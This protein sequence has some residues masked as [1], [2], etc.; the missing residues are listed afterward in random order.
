MK[1]VL[2]GL[3]GLIVVAVAALFI[4]PPLL[5]WDFVKERAAVAVKEATGRDL[6][7]ETLSLSLLPSVSAELKG[8]TL[9]NGP[10]MTSAQMLSMDSLQ[11]EMGLFPLIG[12]SI[13]VQLL[14]LSGLKVS[15][16]K[17]A[18]GQA[19]WEFPAQPKSRESTGKPG[20]AAGGFD[21][22]VA[23]GDV[24][25]ENSSITYIDQIS[26]QQIEI[27]DLGV[28]ATLP[29]FASPLDVIGSFEL[30][31]ERVDLN[32]G[33]ETPKTLAEGAP[34]KI[35]ASIASNHLNLASALTLSQQPQAGLDGG[36]EL[37]IASV[38]ALLSWLDQPLPE[39]QPDPGPVKIAASFNT[40]GN[41][42]V[43]E[44]AIVSGDALDARAKGRFETGG[45][46][47]KI[48]LQLES[49]V[50][51]IDRY[52]PP[53]SDTGAAKRHA[54]HSGAHRHEGGLAGLSGEPI[55]LSGLKGT[56]ADISI[57]MNGIRAGGYEVGGIDFQTTLKEG[58]L[59]AELS[60][61]ELYGGRV[62]GKVSLDGSGDLLDFTSD[63]KIDNVDLGRLSAVGAAGD[64]P[65][66]GV[67]SGV[68][69]AAAK[70]RSPRAL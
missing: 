52:L 61:L 49:S 43:L 28:A 25:L 32:L 15:L 34:A 10:G 40:E 19:N 64:P 22:Q 37:D 60:R 17:N 29:N 18:Q 1:K 9:S 7:V 65:V 2:L 66:A 68:I 4:V 27:I 70:G 38:A 42:V 55:D 62:T 3:L 69:S 11:L 67:A 5:S 57:S 30:N 56:E 54:D 53:P 26:G 6:T 33:V 48:A 51:D 24:R 45:G 35:D 63:L 12:K 41:V 46:L 44:E 50:L 8:V 13:D 59:L 20:T 47:T 58:R 36:A 31:G 39:G 14:R 16:E 23:L 21:W